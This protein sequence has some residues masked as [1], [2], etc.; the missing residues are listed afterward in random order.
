MLFAN[1]ADKIT[2]FTRNNSILLGKIGIS[3]DFYP[4]FP[5]FSIRNAHI[6]NY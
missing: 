3:I 6:F 4:N 5:P 1:S 2:N